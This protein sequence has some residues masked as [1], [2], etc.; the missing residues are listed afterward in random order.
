MIVVTSIMMM[1][2]EKDPLCTQGRI[3][4]ICTFNNNNNKKY[5]KYYNSNY[6]MMLTGKDLLQTLERLI[7][8]HAR[9]PR[10]FVAERQVS[11]YRMCFLFKKNKIT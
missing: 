9:P 1:Y 5:Q 4:K 2:T 3:C 7:W 6:M 10:G 11:G 8:L